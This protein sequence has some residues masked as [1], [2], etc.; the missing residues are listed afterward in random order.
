MNWDYVGNGWMGGWMW[1]LMALLLALLAFGTVAVIRALTMGA[2]DR[3]EAPLAV[4]AGRL[5]AGEITN[6]EYE[7]I[8]ATLAGVSR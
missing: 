2:P 3:T 6:D 8:R 1:I 5:A 7:E 4:A